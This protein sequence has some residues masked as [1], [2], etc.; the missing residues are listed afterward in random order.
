L[1]NYLLLLKK[2][3]I[4]IMKWFNGAGIDGIH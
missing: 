4:F 1:M 3:W 2:L